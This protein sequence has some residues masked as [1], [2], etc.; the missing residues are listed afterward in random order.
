MSERKDL[1]PLHQWSTHFFQ[2]EEKIFA[3]E[4]AI[5]PRSP[6]LK[7]GDRVSFELGDG[8]DGPSYAM[9]VRLLGDDEQ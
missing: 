2:D 6:G 1:V 3:S 9:K 4:S 5:P 8:V 7:A